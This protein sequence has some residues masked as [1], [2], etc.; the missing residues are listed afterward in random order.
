MKLICKRYVFVTRDMEKDKI[1]IQYLTLS[2]DA[3]KQK[4]KEI[5]EDDSILSC[6]VE[7]DYEI[8]MSAIGFATTIKNN[9]VE[10]PDEEV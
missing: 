1:G 3:H 8:D 6:F 7:Y 9:N 2:E 10:V 4:E 5:L